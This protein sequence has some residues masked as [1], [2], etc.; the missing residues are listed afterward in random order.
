MLKVV[1]LSSC[2]VQVLISI[3]WKSWECLDWGQSWLLRHR[4]VMGFWPAQSQV[5]SGLMFSGSDFLGIPWRAPRARRARVLG[6]KVSPLAVS[7]QE[8]HPRGTGWPG[9]AR[10]GRCWGVVMLQ[11]HFYLDDSTTYVHEL[12]FSVPK[13]IRIQEHIS[14]PKRCFK[15]QQLLWSQQ[16]LD[17]EEKHT[18]RKTLFKIDARAPKIWYGPQREI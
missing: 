8:P 12:R 7:R 4:Y 17:E 13:S 14:F 2:Q 18:N 6:S 15:T 5:M 11:D 16:F 9:M 1:K 3:D 10:D